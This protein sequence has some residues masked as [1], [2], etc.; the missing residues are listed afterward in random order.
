MDNDP[1]LKETNLYLISKFPRVRHRLLG[2]AVPILPMVVQII[3]YC[4]FQGD[5]SVV[6]LFVLF[7]GVMS[8]FCAV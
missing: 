4:S 2:A 7:F 6:V 1:K 3:K 5:S 8:Y